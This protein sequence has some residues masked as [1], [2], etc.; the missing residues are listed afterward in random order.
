MIRTK[1]VQVADYD[2][3]WP[4]DFNAVRGEI[5]SVLPAAV[6]TIHHVGSTSVPGL[7]SKPVIDVLVDVVDARVIEEAT[8]SLQALGFEPRGEYGLPGRRYFSR[9]EG[10][11][12]KVHLHAFPSGHEEIDRHLLFRDFLRAHPDEATRYGSLKRTL[13]ESHA[14]DRDAY[15]AAKANFIESLHD[16]ASACRDCAAPGPSLSARLS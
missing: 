15:Q 14:R 12:P 8:P 16:K 13:A 1:A 10:A 3:T 11:G 5:R 2:S 7:A 9:P 4:D 6:A